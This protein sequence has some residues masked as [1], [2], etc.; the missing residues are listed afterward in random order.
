MT[1]TTLSPRPSLTEDDFKLTD[2]RCVRWFLEGFEALKRFDETASADALK[3]AERAL[4]QCVQHYPK[5]LLPKFYLGVIQSVLGDMSQESAIQCFSEFTASDKFEVRA[6]AKYNLALAYL[7][8]YDEENMESAEQELTSLISDLIE[9]GTPVARWRIRKK[10]EDW[11][12]ISRPRIEN[13]YF[14][15][16]VVLC[17][18]QIHLRLW[19]P[20]WEADIEEHGQLADNLLNE[21]KNRTKDIE[22]NARFLEDQA[23]E[24]WAWHWNNIGSVEE[25]RAALEMRIATTASLET[26]VTVKE[27]EP[28]KTE[29][30]LELGQRAL[31]AYRKA[32]E[33]DPHWDSARSNIGRLHWEIFD[34]VKGAIDAYQETLK[35]VEDVDYSHYNLGVLHTWEGNREM[36]LEHFELSPNMLKI[37]G[38]SATWTDAHR[39]LVYELKKIGR[40]EQAIEVLRSLVTEAPGDTE[41]QDD[42]QALLRSRE[43]DRA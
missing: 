29:R 24:I 30:S 7:E 3:E 36:A 43:E 17:H 11:L 40:R 32:L 23:P 42:L 4:S 18:L 19:A 31:D 9:H 21:L 34:D 26:S 35:G 6:A 8:T 20:R 27:P 13:L 41:A 39:L 37:R 33:H 15:A 16:L 12:G 38:R 5:D 28:K 22:R 25:S 1:I 2:K 14:L 10:I